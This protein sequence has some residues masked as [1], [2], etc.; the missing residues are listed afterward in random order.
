[1]IALEYISAGR[2]QTRGQFAWFHGRS[3]GD[4]CN[5]SL[6]QRYLIAAAVGHA[7]RLGRIFDDESGQVRFLEGWA[8]AMAPGHSTAIRFIR[9]LTLLF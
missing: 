7:H 2:T 4:G 1:M 8:P 3:R 9:L 5:R 6:R